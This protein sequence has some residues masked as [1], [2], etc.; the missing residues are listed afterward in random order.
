MVALSGK[1]PLSAFPQSKRSPTLC[2]AQRATFQQF[3]RSLAPDSSRVVQSGLTTGGQ[4][5]SARHQA[6]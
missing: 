6:R 1:Q 5:I 3:S 4:P 2:G